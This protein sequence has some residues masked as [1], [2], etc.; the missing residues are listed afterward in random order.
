MRNTE[1]RIALVHHWLVTMR[2]GERVFEAVAELFPAAELHTLVCDPQGL[3]PALRQRT[4]RTSM[5]QRIP[6]S[7]R[8]YPYFLPLYPW[9]VGSLDL[10]GCP[11]VISSDAAV[12]K[13]VR[14]DSNAIHICYCHT[15]MRYVWDGYVTYSQAAGHLARWGLAL[16]RQRLC[17]WD[18]AAAQRVTHFVANSRNVQKRILECYGRESTVIYP[19]VRTEQFIPDPL[20]RKRENFFLVVSQLVP[21]KRI[22]LVVTA[23][24]RCGRRL[25]IIGE[26][27]ERK[28]LEGLAGPN[29][30][31][32]GFQSEG[33]VIEAM[34]QCEAFVFAGEEDFGIVMAEAQACGTPVIA[35]AKG[36]AREIVVNGT[37]GTLFERESEESLLEALDRF[38]RV[39]FHSSAIRASALKFGRQRFLQEF[40]QFVEER[41]ELPG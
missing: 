10:S 17:Q 38:Q 27:P 12:V 23:F 6:Q 28:K 2:G 1:A 13:G 39:R 40:S 9:A 8:R 32:L 20:G 16:T 29:I 41:V 22:D 24:N 35:L 18:Y 19:P 21:Y 4:I 34:Q 25:V 14:T 5:L 33:T 11:L 37:T 36:G 3:S 15:P 30:R 31:L 26:G 7:T